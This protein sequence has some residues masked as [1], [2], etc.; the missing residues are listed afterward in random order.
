MIF[1]TNPL[2]ADTDGDG[3]GDGKEV[4]KYPTRLDPNNTWDFYSVPVPALFAALNPTTDFKDNRRA[5]VGRA[6]G[7]RVLQEEREDGIR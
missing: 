3:C 7:L 6:V 5:G 2:K 4:T 1:G